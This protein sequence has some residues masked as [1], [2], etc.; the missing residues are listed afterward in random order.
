MKKLITLLVVLLFGVMFLSSCKKDESV[1]SINTTNSD[2]T[3]I[4]TS[5]SIEEIESSVLKEEITC[6]LD[7]TK[8]SAKVVNL[9][10]NEEDFLKGN[11]EVNHNIG[12]LS[13][14]ISS[15]SGYKMSTLNIF[16]K[17]NVKS[18]YISNTYDV[19]PKTNSVAYAIGLKKCVNFDL[20]IVSI[21]GHNYLMEW[22]DNFRMGTEGDHTGFSNQAKKIKAKLLSLLK[23]LDNPKILITGYSRGG[24]IANCLSYYL[25]LDNNIDVSNNLYCYTFEAPAPICADEPVPVKGVYNYINSA[26]IVAKLPPSEYGFTRC[27]QMIELYNTNIDSIIK[28]NLYRTY[29]IEKLSNSHNEFKTDIDV[30]N[31]FIESLISYNENK[32]ISVTTREEFSLRYEKPIEY[33]I[34][35][36]LGLSLLT[37]SNVL[38][39]V[40]NNDNFIYEMLSEYDKL[41]LYFKSLLDDNN[42]S[43][44]DDELKENINKLIS[45]VTGPGSKILSIIKEESSIGSRLIDMHRPE[46]TYAL[47]IELMN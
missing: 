1:S 21:R 28:T 41:Y 46:I 29:S 5:T 7:F 23:D 35:T 19:S 26:D 38:V 30:A 31:Y 40:K 25:S 43:Y 45:F 36:A 32:D 6:E 13:L 3:D 39:D 47:L 2:T 44:N 42:V 24:G 12:L 9:T 14:L 27:G 37:L 22:A 17:L 18:L 20:V 10:F 11:D 33:C 15:Y 16:N 8:G 34:K 4:P